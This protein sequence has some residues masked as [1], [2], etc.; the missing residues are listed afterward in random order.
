LNEI[1]EELALKID[2]G[3]IEGFKAKMLRVNDMVIGVPTEI[4]PRILYLASEKKPKAN[5][6]TVLPKAGVQT[7]DGLWKTYGGHR[8][9]SSPE[10]MPRTYSI[11]NSP[12]KVTSKKGSFTI[13]GNPEPKNSVQKEITIKPLPQKGVQ[14][15]HSIKNIGR[16]PIRMACWG[17][18]V[19]RKNG[20]A[21]IPIK[22]SKTGKRSLLPDRRVILW[23]YTTVSDKRVKITDDFIFL[24]QDPKAP[25]P[26]KIGASANPTWTAYWVDGAAFVKTFSKEEG[27]YPD[28]GCNVEAYTFMNILELETLGP[29]RLVEPSQS[30]QHVETWRIF[31][32]GDLS[33]E[34]EDV[35]KKLEP[36]L[37]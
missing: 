16:W 36:L 1:E 24:L 8:L 20:F 30:I 37:D 5:L 22:P 7:E 31:D 21:V 18:S 9:W 19:M 14:L 29:L 15:V 11:D 35:K 6:F 12:V 32:V 17:L 13:R 23:P 26:T 33:P 10:K 3:E 34:P 4:G 27:E 28:F 25:A 2:E